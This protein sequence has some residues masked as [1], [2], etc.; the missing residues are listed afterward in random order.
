[1][2]P[3]DPVRINKYIRSARTGMMLPREGK[4]VKSMMNMER[5]LIMVN[6]GSPYGEEY[7]LDSDI[8]D[9]QSNK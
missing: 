1:M 7:I 4:F 2:S 3:G 8:S 5:Q 9:E 6:F